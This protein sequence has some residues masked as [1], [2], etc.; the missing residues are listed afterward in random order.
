MEYELVSSYDQGILDITLSGKGGKER[1]VEIASKVF[2]LIKT[3]QPKAVL[4]DIQFIQG[5]LDLMDTYNLV[6]TYPQE[7][8]HLRTAIVD[9][10]ENK[11]ISDFHE[12]VS[13]NAGY[14]ARYFTDGATARA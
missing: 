12:T 5:R 13:E 3:Y 1:S 6:H 11:E 7:T 8:P 10:K 14:I 4:I 9:R 2:N